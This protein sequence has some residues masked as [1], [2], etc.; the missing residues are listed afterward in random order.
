[1]GAGGCHPAFHKRRSSSLVSSKSS[2]ESATISKEPQV[3]MPPSRN[4]R[5]VGD[6]MEALPG[7]SAF[8]SIGNE[9]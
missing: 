6:L 8:R 7:L 9:D 1:M 5:L 3:P 2:S 4:D